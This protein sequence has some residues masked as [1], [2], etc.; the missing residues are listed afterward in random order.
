I[1]GALTIGIVHRAATDAGGRPRRWIE[2]DLRLAPGNSG[3]PLIDAAGRVVGINSMIAGGLALAVPSEI[4][5]RF[6][7]SR[8]A[9]AW[10]GVT[11]Q[12]VAVELPASHGSRGPRGAG[13]RGPR[14]SGA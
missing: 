1:A 10:L 11:T 12:P 3:G 13:P 4:A 5:Q 14:G 2:A 6:V 7:A 8:G 9:R